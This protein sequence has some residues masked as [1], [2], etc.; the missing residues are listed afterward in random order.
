MGRIATWKMVGFLLIM[1]NRCNRKE[2]KASEEIQD[3]ALGT[4]LFSSCKPSLACF[5][6]TPIMPHLAVK[7]DSS[8]HKSCAAMTTNKRSTWTKKHEEMGKIERSTP[9]TIF[10]PQC[11]FSLSPASC[12]LFRVKNCN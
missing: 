10:G 9:L 3:S 8:P 2:R 6:Q 11:R 12:G 4:W 5:L 7:R 1:A